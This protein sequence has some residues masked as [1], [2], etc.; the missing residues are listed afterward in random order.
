MSQ[1]TFHI[2]GLIFGITKKGHTDNIQGPSFQLHSSSQGLKS[3]YVCNKTKHGCKAIRT[4]DTPYTNDARLYHKQIIFNS[5]FLAFLT[6]S[7]SSPKSHRSSSSS[8]DVNSFGILNPCLT[9][10]RNLMA[11]S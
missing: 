2:S 4:L 5:A 9:P 10:L 3:L 1:A 8:S 6:S 7:H 11:A